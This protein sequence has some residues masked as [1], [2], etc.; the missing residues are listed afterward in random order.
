LLTFI[1][2]LRLIVQNDAQQR[3]VDGQVSVVLNEALSVPK[4]PS[5][6]FAIASESEHD[7]WMFA[8]PLQDVRCAILLVISLRAQCHQTIQRRSGVEGAIGAE[9][10]LQ[11]EQFW[12]SWLFSER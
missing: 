1:S 4:T 9:L 8:I 12:T 6:G 2:E 7:C 11:C 10:F 5:T 3:A